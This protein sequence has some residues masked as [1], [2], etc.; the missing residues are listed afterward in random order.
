VTSGIATKTLAEVYLSQG[1]SRK[2]LEIYREILKRDPSNSEIRRAIEDLTRKMARGSQTRTHEQSPDFTRT[3]KIRV[4]EQWRE[5]IRT[6][7]RKR[8]DGKH[9]E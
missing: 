7:R 4:L 3:A 2:A 9:L 6:I 8:K 5:N 1:D